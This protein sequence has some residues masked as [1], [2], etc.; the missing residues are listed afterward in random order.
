MSTKRIFTAAVT[1][2]IHT[3]SMSEY[4]PVTPD[5]IA[6]D[7]FR[8]YN[9][10]A[11]V[12]HIHVRDPE[13]GKPSADTTL[14]LEAAGKI[15]EKCDI[16][17]CFT[18]GGSVDMT[19]E[20]RLKVIPEAKP[21]LASLNAGSLNFALHP[22]LKK[23]KEFQYDWEKPFLEGTENMIFPNTFQSLRGY[24]R[25]FGQCQVKPEIE[26]YDAGMLNNV[27]YLIA[28]GQVQRPVYLQFVL[29]ILG[30]MQATLENFSFLLTSAR[31]M[32]GEFEFSVCAAGRHQFNMCTVS[33]IAGGHARVGL[34][35]NLFLAKGVLAKNSGEQVEKIIRIGK[36]LGVEPATPDEAREILGLKGL[37][38]V[39]Y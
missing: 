10:G 26:V 33:L 28:E 11:A 4:L 8:A 37:D 15:K 13:T 24:S 21:E 30:G 36:E 25:I 7:A 32:L 38:Q 17:V 34:E 29:G 2:A 6:E 12:A 27:A 19:V 1:G 3:P 23:Y 5:E 9:A 14:F 22:V 16:I 31:N 39:A 35:D 18:T 20:D